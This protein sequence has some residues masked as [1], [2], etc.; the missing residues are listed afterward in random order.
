M[1]GNRTHIHKHGN[2][3]IDTRP[4]SFVPPTP[5]RI[6][7]SFP[8]NKNHPKIRQ[9]MITHEQPHNTNHTPITQASPI[10]SCTPQHTSSISQSL[11]ILLSTV[12]CLLYQCLQSSH[13]YSSLPQHHSSTTP[14]SLSPLIGLFPG[15]SSEIVIYSRST[16]NPWL[17]HTVRDAPEDLPIRK[18]HPIGQWG[19]KTSRPANT[20]KC[21]RLGDWSYGRSPHLRRR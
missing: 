12:N 9:T 4:H 17:I 11:S 2:H 10:A 15:G 7:F 20:N 18:T 6:E 16:P 21:E 19:N 1:E 13:L 3:P 8:T 14:E 5:D